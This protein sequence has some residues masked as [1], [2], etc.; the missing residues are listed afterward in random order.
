MPVAFLLTGTGRP[1]WLAAIFPGNAH[2]QSGLSFWPV[3]PPP[4]FAS[5]PLLPRASFERPATPWGSRRE[6]TYLCSARDLSLTAPFRC[7]PRGCWFCPLRGSLGPSIDSCRTA[8]NGSVA[9]QA[10]SKGRVRASR[11]SSPWRG[12]QAGLRERNGSR[13]QPRSPE[14]GSSAAQRDFF[15]TAILSG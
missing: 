7:S 9:W 8:G 10:H 3:F 12:L 14:E 13:I 6:A 5:D 15:W 11:A 1:C 4:G 2:G